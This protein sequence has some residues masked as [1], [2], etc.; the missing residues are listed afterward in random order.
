VVPSLTFPGIAGITFDPSGD[1]FVSYDS[2]TLFSGQQQSVAEVGSNGFLVNA[3]VFG[4]TGASAFPGALTSVGASASLPSLSS[5]GEILELQPNGQLF[6]F[7]PVSGTSS[8]YDNQPDDTANAS[9][10]FDVQTGA[11]VD[12]TGKLSLSGTSIVID[13]AGDYPG[14]GPSG[15]VAWG[16]GTLSGT[17]GGGGGGLSAVEPEPAWQS[18]VVPTSLDPIHT[19]ALPDVAVD[20]GSAQEYDVFTSTLSGSSVSAS[21]V[22]WLGDAG[23]SAGSPIW[24]GLIAIADQGRVLAGGTPLTGS[25]QTLPALYALPAAD[26]HDI[27]NGNNGDPA[28]PGYDLA[29]GLGS[30]V[31][32]LLVPDLA[33]YEV[34]G[35]TDVTKVVVTASPA[36]PVFGQPV[37]LSATVSLASPS[38]GVPTGSVTFQEGATLLGT[39][40]LVDGVAQ[41][42]MAPTAAGN[43]TITAAYSG[44]HQPQTV[45]FSLTVG[46]ATPVL[47]RVHPANITAGT[48][49]G[50]AQLDAAATFDGMPL[51]GVLTY[52]PAAGT[53]LPAGSGQTLWVSFTPADAADFQTVTASVPIN[54]LPQPTQTP[55]PTPTPAPAMVIGELP[56]FRRMLSKHRKPTGKAVLTGFT[57]DFNMPLSAAAVS[58]PANYQLDTITTRR[59]KRKLAHIL[60]PLTTFTVVSTPASGSVTLKLT[61]TASF[62]QDGQ[63]TVLPGVTSGSG[64]VLIGPT[65]FT[66]TPGGKTI[67]PS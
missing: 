56:V 9:T 46:Q 14:T 43:E 16:D 26:L 41:L 63:I 24:A 5:S 38:T 60:Q 34:T 42:S 44:D 54:V 52:T 45:E 39:A 11:P 25:T 19:R 59:V 4:T 29:S 27:V 13:S 20:S 31:A 49:L 30:P 37:T 21:A 35:A 65:V 28:V 18:G 66:I 50:A 7:N 6:V 15:E 8:Q 12:L 33:A 40:T 22:G 64:N 1:V 51:P 47:T 3:S 67:K 48:P 57:L 61:G 58:N 32:N 2:T 10:V 55:Q 62:S 53:V 36:A 23:T 17:T